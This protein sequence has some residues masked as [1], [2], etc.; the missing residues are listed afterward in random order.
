VDAVFYLG[1]GAAVVVSYPQVIRANLALL[2]ALLVFETVRYCFDF[3]RFRRMASYHTYLAK[4]WGLLLIAAS[5]SLLCFGHFPI[6]VTVA[7]AW[8]IVCDAEGLAISIVLLEW[9]PDVRT[10]ARAFQLRRASVLTRS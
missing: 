10:L 4:A 1:V 9:R 2:V 8:G 5:V 3:V 6:L 7:I